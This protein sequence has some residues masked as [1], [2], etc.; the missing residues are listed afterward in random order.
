[1]ITQIMSLAMSI[2]SRGFSD[3]KIDK[4]TKQLR[5]LSCFGSNDLEKCPKLKKSNHSEFFYCGG[6]GCGDH[7]HTWLLRNEK[8]YAKLDYPVLKC[9]FKMPGFTNYDPSFLPTEIKDR[10]QKIENYNLEKL[11]LIKVT[12]NSKDLE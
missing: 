8:D 4:E 5:I 1:M 3:N 10:K 2:A 12:V 11:N 6:C 7:K 9:P